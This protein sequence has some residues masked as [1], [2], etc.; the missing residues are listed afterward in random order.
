MAYDDKD[1]MMFFPTRNGVAQGSGVER[2]MLDS[3]GG[4]LSIRTKILVNPDGSTTRLKTRGGMPE[5]VTESAKK[6]IEPT[7]PCD[8]GLYF[9]GTDNYGERYPGGAYGVYSTGGKLLRTSDAA[10]IDI[11][12]PK[13]VWGDAYTLDTDMF[14]GEYGR[15][16]SLETEKL[17]WAFDWQGVTYYVVASATTISFYTDPSLEGQYHRGTMVVSTPTA[18]YYST[19]PTYQRVHSVVDVNSTGQRFIIESY[20]PPPTAAAGDSAVMHVNRTRVCRPQ[21]LIAAI[22]CWVVPYNNNGTIYFTVEWRDLVVF[23]HLYS[24]ASI[25]L[26]AIANI[27]LRPIQTATEAPPVTSNIVSGSFPSGT[28]SRKVYKFDGTVESDSVGTINA[29]GLNATDIYPQMTVRVTICGVKYKNDEIDFVYTEFRQWKMAT[30]LD[31]LSVNVDIKRTVHRTEAGTLGPVTE[32]ISAGYVQFEPNRYYNQYGTSTSREITTVK[33][34]ESVGGVRYESSETRA[35]IA[36]P[37]TYLHGWG[38]PGA[39]YG[40][41][42]GWNTDLGSASIPYASPNAVED[43]AGGRIVVTRLANK[44]FG[45]VEFNGV[46]LTAAEGSISATASVVSAFGTT[47]SKADIGAVYSGLIFPATTHYTI[48]E[49]SPM[50]AA[51]SPYIY[52]SEHPTTKALATGVGLGKSVCWV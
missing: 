13:P 51:I 28:V 36:A 26:P 27:P 40:G 12:G 52:A 11:E 24:V 39:G 33:V 16:C 6:I 3:V 41:L 48:N 7:H 43:I 2:K 47:N 18:D 30:V 4:A 19:Y 29:T 35:H 10:V 5:F 46:N 14:S 49:R 21:H 9:N 34:L 45:I 31:L 8:H 50:E 25:T 20:G 17:T 22:E 15:F 32:E 1:D 37:L 38:T 23:T 42:F 44:V